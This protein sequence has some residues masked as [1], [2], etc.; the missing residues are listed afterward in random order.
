[1]KT[2]QR[3]VSS[4]FFRLPTAETTPTLLNSQ[5]KIT[6]ENLDNKNSGKYER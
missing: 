1:M 5:I 6:N 3:R 2:P 4:P